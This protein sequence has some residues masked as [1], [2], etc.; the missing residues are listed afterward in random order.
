MASNCKGLV[1]VNSADDPAT[2]PLTSYYGSTAVDNDD[3]KCSTH[4]KEGICIV[5][6]Q[7]NHAT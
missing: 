4:K 6:I 1:V 2:E 7:L 5:C 3:K